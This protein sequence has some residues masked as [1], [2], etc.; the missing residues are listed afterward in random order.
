MTRLNLAL[1]GVLIV[2]ALMMV[3]TAYE[4]RRLFA[5][6]ERAKAEAARLESD[7]VRLLAERHAQA[8]NLRVERLARDKLHMAPISPAVTQYVADAPSRAVSA[9]G[10]RP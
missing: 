4:A 2:S 9:A 7:H 6:I 5:D 10:G 3:H 1:L 8:T